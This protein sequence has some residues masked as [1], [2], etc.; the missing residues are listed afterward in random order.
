MSTTQQPAPPG[1]ESASY[2]PRTVRRA[3]LAGSIGTLIEYYD[4]S[5][6]GY[7]AVAIAPQFFPGND[8]TASMLAALAVFATG[9]VV[10]PIGGVFFG[11]IGDRWGRRK[12]LVSSV[13]CMGVASSVTGL[14]PTYGQIGVVAAVLLFLTRMV[15]GISSGGESVGAY[16]YIYESAP[17]QRRAFLG[18]V[19]PI[20]SNLGF[21]FAAATAGAISAFTTK[22]QMAEWGWRLPF[23][24]AVP[25]TLICLWARLR[26]EDT[27]EFKE[28]A[29]R[30]DI[31]TAPIREV[32]STHRVPLLQSVGLAMAQ[33]GA[34]FLGLTYIGIYMTTNLGFD[35]TKVYWLSSG[36][37]FVTV[38]L[39]VPA[40]WLSARFGCRRVLMGGLL[41][42][43]V[44]AY[45]A[46][47][48]MG[49]HSLAL[50]GAA[51]VLLMLGSAFVQ[52]PA[53]SLWPHLFERRVRYTGMAI[54]YNLGTV[55]AGGTAPYIAAFLV[56]K[57]GNLLSPAFFVML[58]CLIGIGSLFTVR[59]DV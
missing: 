17:P 55:L 42:F 29:Q 5:I 56:D 48:L 41:A 12:A 38:L 45:P 30:A 47:M 18:A 57:T 1:E 39:M 3:M 7:L 50:A 24:M 52:V 14:L 46:M 31:P 53:A 9:L 23:L 33:G 6:Y 36:V 22:D 26:I 8:P 28:A 11:W 16:T 13:L 10:R 21:M 58:V 49:R 37:V 32:L 34:I 44:T 4:F 40:G 2:D 59:K 35:T 19:T 27:P 51:Y 43:L 20:G 25:L 54:G 15:Q